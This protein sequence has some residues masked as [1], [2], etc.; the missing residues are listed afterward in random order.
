M[1]FPRRRER[2]LRVPRGSL[3]DDCAQV[4]VKLLEF[5]ITGLRVLLQRRASPSFSGLQNTQ[6]PPLSLRA[7][8]LFSPKIQVAP[9]FPE[10]KLGLGG[11][12]AGVSGLLNS[13]LGAFEV[14]ERGSAAG[15]GKL[16]W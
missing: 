10:A 6:R 11:G 2:F 9:S 14:M 7:L 5:D 4:F 3:H 8:L 16:A 13:V 12:E 15:Y 1:V